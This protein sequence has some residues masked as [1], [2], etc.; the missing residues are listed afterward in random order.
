MKRPH[1][2]APPTGSGTYLRSELLLLANATLQVL[3]ESRRA[4]VVCD[5]DLRVLAAAP[6]AGAIAGITAHAPLPAEIASTIGGLGRGGSAIVRLARGGSLAVRIHPL[7]GLHPATIALTVEEAA[8]LDQAPPLSLAASLGLGVRE[9]QLVALLRRGMSNREIAAS[10]GLT[11]STVKTYLYE[12]FAK[13]GVETR[14]Q[15]VAKFD[16]LLSQVRTG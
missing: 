9:R 13:L 11:E 12:L 4:I 7:K 5:D 15:L 16:A 8:L 10:L 1:P 6:A 14:M 2:E 3:E